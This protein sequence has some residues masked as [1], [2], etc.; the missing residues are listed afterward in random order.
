MNRTAA[1]SIAPFFDR[2]C[3]V[4][5]AVGNGVHLDAKGFQASLLLDLSRLLNTRCDLTIDEFMKSPGHVMNYGMAATNGLSSNAKKDLQ[6]L[7][8]LVHHAIKLFEPR[9]TQVRVKAQSDPQD[10]KNVRVE[11]QAAVIFGEQTLRFS[12][13]FHLHPGQVELVV[14]PEPA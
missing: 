14:Q 9:L 1:S 5:F 7:E 3:G 11:I 12:P 2:L 6:K 13:S 4:D 8:Q 10:F